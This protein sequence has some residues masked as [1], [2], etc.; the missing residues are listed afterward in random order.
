MGNFDTSTT[1]LALQR[2]FDKADASD[3]KKEKLVS[4]L[5]EL[6]DEELSEIIQTARAKQ[7]NSYKLTG[8]L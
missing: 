2:T 8:S 1:D 4:L 3:N 7:N 6:S 5:A